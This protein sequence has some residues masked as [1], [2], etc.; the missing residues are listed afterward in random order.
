MPRTRNYTRET[1][2]YLLSHPSIRD[3]LARGL[4]NHSALAR[5]ICEECDISSFEAVLAATQRF[6][7][8]TS[9]HSEKK[10][11]SLV[12]NAQ[13]RVNNKIAVLVATPPRDFEPIL[14]L[15]RSIRKARGTFNVIDGSEVVTIIIS[16]QHLHMA[17]SALRQS[18]RSEVKGLSQIHLIFDEGIETTPGVVAH[19]YG[20]LAFNG[21]NV[22][23]EMS[24]WT[25]LIL[26]I[27]ENDVPKALATL[28]GTAVR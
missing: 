22:R 24:C 16:E 7:P 11:R 17:R 21:V 5:L 6:V 1:R 15:Q 26:I 9:S 18:I 3:C 13:V 28:N 8:S 23:E 10:I 4:I 19:F 25:D 12:K 14:A 2:A 20:L 27:D